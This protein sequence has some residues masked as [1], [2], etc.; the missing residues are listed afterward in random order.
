M[1][2]ILANARSLTSVDDVEQ[3][4]LHGRLEVSGASN[5]DLEH[6]LRVAG[7]GDRGLEEASALSVR[8]K[9]RSS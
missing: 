7:H 2:R 1:N 5:V 6:A 4:V 9:S 3:N 8:K